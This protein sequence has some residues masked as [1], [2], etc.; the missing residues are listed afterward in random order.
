M[1]NVLVKN[2]T[3]HKHLGVTFSQTGK[4]H[5][6]IA[7]IVKR[8]W[9]RIGI[10]R[11]LKFHLNRSCLEKLYITFIRPL[12]EYSDVLWDNCTAEQSNELEAIQIEAAR[13]VTGATKLCNIAKLY[14]DLKWDTLSNR[15][16]KHKLVLFYKMKQ[17]ITPSYLTNLIPIP[18]ENRYPLRNR[19]DIPT[20]QTRTSLYQ[21]SFLPSVIR[22]W[23]LL[24]ENVKSSQ[25]LPIFKH[26]ISP[27]M[28]KPPIYYS[29]GNRL[30]QILHSRLRLE[31]SSL[32]YDLH[33]KSIVES[34]N[35][36]CGEIETT[37]HF[38]FSCSSYN[39]F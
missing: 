5:S 24:P 27:N 23:N 2:V 31:C 13:I 25:T 28:Q 15:R 30:G 8:A 34:P 9:Q 11:T 38:L 33:R 16:R 35:C 14:N 20:I 39:A 36:A 6:H 29:V 32:N 37:R 3:D 26:R 12:L 7:S 18:Q 1:N 4:W 19:N 22:Q 10:L 21:E 17:K